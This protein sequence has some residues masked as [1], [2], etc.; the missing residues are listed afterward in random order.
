MDLKISHIARV[1]QV[2]WLIACAFVFLGFLIT[3]GNS[4]AQDFLF[5]IMQVLSFP[6]SLLAPPLIVATGFLAQLISPL[7][8]L[9]TT[10][11]D[12]V[13]VWFW[14]FLLGF[15]QWFLLVPGVVWMVKKLR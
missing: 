9:L 15:V 7:G 10:F 2:A 13:M 6:I 4:E 11:G 1:A 5:R 12:Y 14:L 3:R 8:S